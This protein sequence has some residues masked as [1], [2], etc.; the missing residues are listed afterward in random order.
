M[1]E[2]N[3]SKRGRWCDNCPYVANSDLLPRTDVLVDSAAKTV[4]KERESTE[5]TSALLGICTESSASNI[6]GLC[7]ECSSNHCEH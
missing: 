5:V 4:T 3:H 6:A 7:L 2:E 1:F